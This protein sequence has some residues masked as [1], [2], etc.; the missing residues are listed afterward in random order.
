MLRPLLHAPL[1]AIVLTNP[2]LAQ[3]D[4]EDA[5]LLATAC[6]QFAA[7]L[8]R[9]LATEG[10]QALS[11]A[12]IAIA[13]LMLE[14]GARGETAAE[15]QRALHLPP[16]LRGDRLAQAC[17]SLLDT[18]G[19]NTEGKRAKDWPQLRI[20][21]DLWTQTGFAIRAE[22]TSTLRS[23]F[24]A[25]HREVDFRADPDR[26]RRRINEHVADATEDRIRDLLTPDLVGSATRLVLTNAMWFRG[27][28]QHTFHVES[29]QARPFHLA[30]GEAVQAPTMHLTESFRYAESDAWQCLSMAFTHGPIVCEVMLPRPGQ[31]LANAERDLTLGAHTAKL[32]PRAVA[33]QLPRF[34]I[35]GSFRLPEAL[36]ALGIHAAFTPGKA[37]F[38]GIRDANDLVVDEVVHR[39]W[40]NVDEAG[41]EAAAATAILMK[42]GSARPNDLVHFVADRPFALAL[43]DSKTGLVLFSG[44]VHDPRQSK[45]STTPRNR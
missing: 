27:T 44:R 2:A 35:E 19:S 3:R 30:S 13:L 8:A 1:F 42:I 7:D 43:R 33:V 25:S 39:A 15:L 40:L 34:Q 28:W 18:I 22:Y 17:G 45:A 9:K 16:A 11:P 41:A 14:P 21:N 20:V 38:S 10:N 12:S 6:N 26:A 23:G 4:L 5:K 31:S 36:R 29:T 37:D 32:Q 24:G